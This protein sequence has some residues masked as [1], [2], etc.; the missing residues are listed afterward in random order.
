MCTCVRVK[1]HGV[2]VKIGDVTQNQS[3][4]SKLSPV[5]ENMMLQLDDYLGFYII[6]YVKG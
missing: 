1:T 2:N 4:I 3:V 5:F 6:D